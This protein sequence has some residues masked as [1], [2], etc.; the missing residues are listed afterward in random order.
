MAQVRFLNRNR[1]NWMWGLSFVVLL[2]P[3]TLGQ[4][5]AG[6]CGATVTAP[7]PTQLNSSE[8]NPTRPAPPVDSDG[9]GFSDDKEINGTPGTD[10]N[11]PTDNPNNVRDS[12]GDGCSDYDELNFDGFCDNDPNTPVDSDG[13]GFSDDKEINGTTGTD[14][15]DPTDN[16]NN[17]RD[18]DGDGCSDYDELNFPN[19]CDNDPN[20]PVDSDGDGF[21]DDVELNSTPG[22]D[23]N[24]PTDNPNN[25]RDSDGDGCSDFDER[26]LANSCDNDPYTSFCETTFYNAD[27][28]FGF[29][30][31]A[32]A[33]SMDDDGL[34]LFSAQW[35]F[36]FGSRV[37]AVGT[38]VEDVP[39]QS[40]EDYVASRNQQRET[41]F[42]STI[43]NSFPYT[44]ADGTNAFLTVSIEPTAT[45]PAGTV[46][47]NLDSIAGGFLYF[48]GIF[49]PGDAY[50]DAA[51]AFMLGIM[52][53]LCI[54]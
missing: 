50:T 48:L 24:D 30:L 43:V 51:D 25:V 28:H 49:V 17:V 42:G 16:P 21:S 19:F 45:D 2:L 32:V 5:S 44:L 54:D 27:Y 40:L 8:P 6:G 13:D 9:D 31:P 29:D 23:P 33:E 46:V 11:D 36:A 3:L 53:S 41:N 14:P 34:G 18:S 39:P 47:Y 37:M 4:S 35:A 38:L 12:D 1:L 20:T 52:D 7:G 15:H 26:T 10:P 22:T